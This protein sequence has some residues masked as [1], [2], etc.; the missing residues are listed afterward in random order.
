[1]TSSGIPAEAFDFYEGLVADNSKAFWT[2][3]KDTYETAVRGPLAELG[4][5]LSDEFGQPHLYRPYRDVRFS[6]DKTPYKDHQGMFVEMRNGLGWYAQISVRGLMVAGGWYT[7]TSQQVA[8][9]RESVDA[10]DAGELAALVKALR[11]KG[12][13]VDGQQ[14]KSRP[15]G[16][17]P[18]H[19]RLE[20]LRYRTLYC[21]RS[22]EP[23]AWMGT[24][25]VISKVAQ[26]WRA[27]TPLMDWVADHV[28]PGEAPVGSRR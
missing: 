9:Y 19:P 27:M 3:H 23:A 16:T 4:R 20:W 1:M 13:A 24:R 18:D 11:G 2:E 22:W 8:R 17:D 10:D 26:S 28:G 5:Q 25:R 6:K 7:S 14:L 12:F 21:H 15:R